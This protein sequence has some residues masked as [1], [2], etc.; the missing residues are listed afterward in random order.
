MA[1]QTETPD[2][3]SDGTRRVTSAEVA[4]AVGVSRATVS[5]VLN[6]T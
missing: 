3:Q 6:N 4:R 1:E 2:S 5:Y